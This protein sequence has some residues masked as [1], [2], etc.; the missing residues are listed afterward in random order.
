MRFFRK[1]LRA[2]AAFGLLFS[3]PNL[4]HAQELFRKSFLGAT[5][6]EPEAVRFEPDGKGTKGR[7]GRT[8]PGWLEAAD[9]FQTFP[10]HLD[11]RAYDE[12][13][14]SEI[15]KRETVRMI[16]SNLDKIIKESPLVDA[17]D[18]AGKA[19]NRT[20]NLITFGKTGAAGAGDTLPADTP[21]Y[22]KRNDKVTF[23]FD[24][25]REFAPTLSVG[26]TAR[27]VSDPRKGYVLVEWRWG[28]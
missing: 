1:L 20:R 21:E 17:Y 24:A 10:S 12:D 25:F 26:K 14:R 9:G 27:V 4:A 22:A 13:E 8:F 16:G 19:V 11:Y 2:F 7:S 6:T 28:F 18:L 15:A 5:T 3:I 23:G